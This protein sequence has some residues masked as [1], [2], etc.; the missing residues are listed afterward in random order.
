MLTL[1]LSLALAAAD[2]P[3]IVPGK[4]FTA[5]TA[6][7]ARSGDGPGAD[8]QAIA[9]FDVV[10]FQVISDAIAIGVVAFHV[11]GIDRVEIAA[12]GG[13]WT[14]VRS[15]TR[16][17]ETGVWEYWATLRAADVA[18][19][20]IE[21]R[22]VA[23]PT[24]GR[25]RVLDGLRLFA[26]AHGTLR[27]VE[28]FADATK[29]DDARGDG[30]AARPYR[31]IFA[32]A[33]AVGEAGGAHGADGG[34]VRLAAGDY[35][36]AGRPSYSVAPPTTT[37]AWLTI[38]PAPGVSSE[39]VRITSST[40]DGAVATKLLRLENLTV[41]R[42]EITAPTPLGASIWFDGCALSG[43]GRTDNVTFA[44]PTSFTGG[45]YATNTTIRDC[46]DGF[47]RA[48]LQRNV[49]L[50][51]LGSDAFDD[52]ALVVDCTVD[53]I[54]STGTDAHPDV[55]Q[56]NGCFDDTIV[57]GLRALGCK[58]EGVF[59]RDGATGERA[60]NQAFVN[61]LIELGSPMMGQWLESA[62]HL[63]FWHV[64]FVGNAFQIASDGERRTTIR[65]LS[66]RN[67]V[68][69]KLVLSAEIDGAARDAIAR[70]NHFVDVTSF[71][72]V[73][74]GANATRGARLATLFADPAK[75]DYRPADGSP[76]RRRVTTLLVPCDAAGR[77][78]A[79]PAA[80][81]A[82]Q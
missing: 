47:D 63:L 56:F 45:I 46:R 66:I 38:A 7:P 13:P 18:D 50:A 44:G 28:R 23:Y 37:H 41:H 75:R 53:G 14:A 65:N 62:D 73:A 69:E 48:A 77:A 16:N 79:V 19:G 70:D 72:G 30:S 4:G 43:S 40:V 80:I 1:A 32:A 31:S 52:P 49:H 71:G 2:A 29:G 27:H 10:P 11:N 36:F 3:R 24:R 76:L 58:S 60:S 17:P 64:T 26:N 51:N 20:P 34:V 5:P 54:D 15:M 42:A 9:R 59:A 39:A 67:S 25:P 33:R 6:E 57:Y 82:L 78:L 81:G 61:V 35:D 55:V 12:Q 21:V 22:A 8:A 68:F 74:I